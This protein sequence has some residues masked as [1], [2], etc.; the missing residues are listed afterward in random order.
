MKE[1]FAEDELRDILFNMK[2]IEP[3]F[4]L[5]SE[6]DLIK[7]IQAV[8][9]CGYIWTQKDK[10]VGFFHPKNELILNFKG[11]HFYTPESIIE[12]YNTVW[13]KDSVKNHIRKELKVKSLKSC[14]L[15]IISFSLLLFIDAKYAVY[16]ISALFLRF[17]YFT[18]RSSNNK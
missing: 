15:W 13:S 9:K 5:W 2:R 16:V 7:L 3:A 18:I 11:L 12:T 8:Y 17:I 1:N 6:D 4:N 14:L 10:D